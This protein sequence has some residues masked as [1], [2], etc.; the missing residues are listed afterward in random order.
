MGLQED[1]TSRTKEEI[2]GSQLSSVKMAFVIIHFVN[3]LV[4]N[5]IHSISSVCPENTDECT[6]LGENC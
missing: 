3:L 1:A 2:L 4:Q 6:V 5:V